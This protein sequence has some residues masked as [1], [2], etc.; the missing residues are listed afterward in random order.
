MTTLSPSPS[1]TPPGPRQSLWQSLNF[2][3]REPQEFLL[4]L[5]QYGDI[6]HIAFPGNFHSYFLNHPDDIQSAVVSAGFHRGRAMQRLGSVLGQGLLTSEE[7]YHQQQRHMVQPAFYQQQVATYAQTITA[8]YAQVM[9]TW[10][11]GQVLPLTPLLGSLTALIATQTFLGLDAT[12]TDMQTFR[13][14]LL[15]VINTYTRYTGLPFFHRLLTLHMLPATHAFDMAHAR[16][17]AFLDHHI[18]ERQQQGASG[19]DVLSLLL[20]Q[21]PP[22]PRQQIQDQV[23]TMLFAGH[24][25]MTSWL[26]WTWYLLAEHPEI[27]ARVHAEWETVLGGRTPTANDVGQ[28]PYT[29]QVLN[30]SLRLYPPIISLSRT[31]VDPYPIH[32]YEFP[33]G[34]NIYMSQLIVHRDPRWWPDPLRVDP[35]R[36]LPGKEQDRPKY[37]FFPFGGG[38]RQCVGEAFARFEA[39]LA[40]AT[41]GQRWRLRRVTQAPI[42]FTRSIVSLLPADGMPMRFERRS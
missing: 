18:A 25:T 7:P 4:S 8:S 42:R 35:D 36:F 41:M 1:A 17:E 2:A 39:V 21:E 10:Q 31:L 28:L 24:E 12:M 6:V 5:A 16:L 22:L 30:E 38:P 34:A 33:A 37:A 29:T 27:E 9:L 14:D 11:D 15:H 13:K 20:Q 32:P 3:R 26:T 19:Q 23:L 40:L